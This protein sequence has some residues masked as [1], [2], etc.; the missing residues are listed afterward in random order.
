MNKRPTEPV[1][2]KPAP[3]PPISSGATGK[4]TPKE[5]AEKKAMEKKYPFNKYAKG[6]NVSSRADGVA[7]KGK[8]RGMQVKM[9][10]GGMKGC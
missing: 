2:K 5:E 3:T 4:R 1:A 8:T 9:A 7:K 6:G 10:A